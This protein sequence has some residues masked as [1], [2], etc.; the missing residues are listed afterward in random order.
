MKKHAL[1]IALAS[2]MMLPS[3]FAVAAEGKIQFDG[4]ITNETC[5]LASKSSNIVVTMGTWST[6]HFTTNG[7]T[8]TDLA[9]LEITLTGCE[10]DGV[11]TFKFTGTQDGD[12]ALLRLQN[13]GL[14]STAKGVAVG[15][16]TGTNPATAAERVKFDG[17]PLTFNFVKGNN[18]MFLKAF[19]EMNAAAATDVTP[20]EAKANATFVVTYA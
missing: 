3:A 14:P 9:D 6:N 10:K 2:A 17:S 8:Y 11:A 1:T 16:T 19:Y 18:T 13:A 15:L 4:K 5:S 12:A 20:G 7:N